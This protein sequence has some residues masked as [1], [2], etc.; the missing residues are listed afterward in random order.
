MTARLVSL[1]TVAMAVAGCGHAVS[2]TSPTLVVPTP[3]VLVAPSVLATP[4]S[5][6]SPAG[7]WSGSI[8]DA[9][10]GDGT[11]QLSLNGEAGATLTGTWS[12]AFKSGERL[13]GPA[14]AAQ[15]S[16]Y[17]ISLVVDPQPLCG[18]PSSPAALA[19]TLINVALTSSRLTAATGRISCNGPSF[20]RVD[21]SK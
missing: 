6:V 2:P 10:S 12:A 4:P 13:S 14:F 11:A 8:S 18:S 3:P 20:G 5:P 19:F 9:I 17:V 16:G 15:S 21:F 1:I 7:N